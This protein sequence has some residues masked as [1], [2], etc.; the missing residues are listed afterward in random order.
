V[1]ASSTLGIDGQVDIR[2]PVTNLSG[3]VSPLPSGFA[4]ST[5]L[6]YDRCAARLQ[7]GRVSSF[8]KRGRAGVPAAPGGVLPGIPDNG[9]HGMADSG[10]KGG[11]LRE[12]TTSH[13]GPWQ[14]DAHGSLQI[15]SWPTRGFS[16]AATAWPC[17]SH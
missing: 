2:A 10:R 8:V 4:P 12:T 7:E 6:L 5:T 9:R 13:M 16:Q 15:Q 3:V 14:V 11:Q 1:S 17:S